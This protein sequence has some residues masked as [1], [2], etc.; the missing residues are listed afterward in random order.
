[1]TVTT[2]TAAVRPDYRPLARQLL[3]EMRRYFEDPEHEAD[4][5]RW[6][7]EQKKEPA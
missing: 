7:K 3:D 6:L 1:M 4:F 5:Q 2:E